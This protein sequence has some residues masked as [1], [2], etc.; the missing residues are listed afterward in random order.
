M[1]GG[2]QLVR[3][4]EK[5][6]EFV[7]NASTTKALGLDGNSTM[8]DFN[9]A[10]TRET[11]NLAESASNRLNKSYLIPKPQ[12]AAQKI[13]YDKLGQSVAKYS[14]ESDMHKVGEHLITVDSKLGNI[15]AQI[16][17]SPKR[18]INNH[19]IKYSLT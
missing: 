1:P 9:N 19:V 17:K 8:Q 3:M 6:E 11:T 15:T 5:G 4:N 7:V 2:E 18:S 16:H 10:I 14:P 12:Q 13:D